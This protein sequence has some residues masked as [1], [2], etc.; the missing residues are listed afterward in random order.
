V[1]A[2]ELSKKHIKFHDWT[3]AHPKY[4]R[5][6]KARKTLT[7]DENI[8]S[9]FSRSCNLTTSTLEVENIKFVG[10]VGKQHS[11][12]IHMI[13]VLV[14]TARQVSRLVKRK[15]LT[16]H[17]WPSLTAKAEYVFPALSDL[18]NTMNLRSGKS[19]VLK[20]Q[21]HKWLLTALLENSS[22]LHSVF[23]I[24]YLSHESHLLV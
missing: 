7:T 16:V 9:L 12:L 15:F 1:A 24:K 13:G 23:E 8:T 14:Y 20:L 3:T 2:H 17:T 21:S 11:A 22:V 19:D 6:K 5:I 18:P 10:S 4:Q